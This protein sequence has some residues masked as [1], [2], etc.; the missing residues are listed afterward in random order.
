[1][2]ENPRDLC[3]RKI[4]IAQEAG[5]GGDFFLRALASQ[6]RASICRTA[7]L[8]DD[9]AMNGL[10]RRAVPDRGRLALVG[11]ADR[12]DVG[13][14]QLRLFDRRAR[15]LDD[16]SPDFLRVVF[17]PAGLGIELLEFL[18]RRGD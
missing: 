18:L 16:A 3:P 17:H 7:I 14:F 8:P 11:N 12:C 15:R 1:M 9:C 2:I 6:F 13:W 10:S 4:W 5:T